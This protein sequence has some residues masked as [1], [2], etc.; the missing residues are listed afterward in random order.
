MAVSSQRAEPNLRR[1]IAGSFGL[2]IFMMILVRPVLSQP[3]AK[4]VVSVSGLFGS[5][6]DTYTAYF[7]YNMIRMRIGKFTYERS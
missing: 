5:L 6:T 4:A 3:L 1:Y 7:K 2:F